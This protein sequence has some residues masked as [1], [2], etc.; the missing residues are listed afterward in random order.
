MSGCDNGLWPALAFSS[1]SSSLEWRW[2]SRAKC[3][4]CLLTETPLV[5]TAVKA[6][7]RADAT[8]RTPLGSNLLLPR[9]RASHSSGTLTLDEVKKAAHTRFDAIDRDHDG[10]LDRKKLRGIVSANEF[11][12]GDADKDGTLDKTEYE[13]LVTEHFQTADSNHA[14]SLDQKDLNSRPRRGLL[15]LLQ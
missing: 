15:R 12:K 6:S 4:I 5:A 13:T 7:A 11:T 10:T 9:R 1:F 3:S 2:K 8:R 14:S